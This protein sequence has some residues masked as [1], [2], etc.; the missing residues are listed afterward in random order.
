M[1]GTGVFTSLGFQLVETQNSWSILILWT[2]GGII[3]LAGAFSYAELGAYFK[4][5]GGEYHYLSEVFHPIV[6]YLS[7]WVSI[8]V[9]FS[10]PVALAAM[11]MGSYLFAAINIDPRIS[12]SA[13]IMLVTLI[14]SVNIDY[15]SRF[16]NIVTLFKVALIALFI[17]VGF[18]FASEPNAL[19]WSMAWKN[20]LLMPAFAVSLIFVTYSYTGWN[21][22]AY[23]VDEISDVKRNLP[24]ALIRG[25]LVVTVLYVLLQIAF[26][27]HAEIEQLSGELEVGQIVAENLFGTTAGNLISMAIALFLVSSISAMIWVGPRVTMV[28]AEDH[29]L[30]NFLRQKNRNGIPV[31]A[32]WFQSA[33]SLLMIWTGTFEQVLV[34]CGFILLLFGAMAV[35]STFFLDRKQGGLVYRNPTHPWFPIIFIAVSVWILV[36]LIYERPQESLLGLSNLILGLI[37]YWISK[38]LEKT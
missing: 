31:R 5:S 20:E 17:V 3:A 8:S 10:A 29:R 22:A 34:Y 14:H 11:A 37:T 13:A 1:I 38:K 25:T 12:A 24:R 26:L 18:V 30:W 15:S 28:M 19:N 9:G 23:I 32:I 2:L 27:K 7:G 4:R 33:I 6:G 21:A 36:F 35:L 16:Q